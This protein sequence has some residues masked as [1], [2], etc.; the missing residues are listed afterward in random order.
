MFIIP[1]PVYLKRTYKLLTIVVQ[2]VPSFLVA[3]DGK[4][5]LKF[6]RLH[7]HSAFTLAHL[8]P[9]ALTS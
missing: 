3:A 4:R 7:S 8:L 6:K 2:P 1:L 5:M 9:A